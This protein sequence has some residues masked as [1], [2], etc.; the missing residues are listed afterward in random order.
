ME[1]LLLEFKCEVTLYFDKKAM[2]KKKLEWAK[3][4]GKNQQSTNPGFFLL[5]KISVWRAYLHNTLI[6]LFN[7]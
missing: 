5:L 4:Q 2:R 7:I 6:I 3:H 1:T